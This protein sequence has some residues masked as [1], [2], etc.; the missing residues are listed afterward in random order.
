[1][2]NHWSSI[3][4][5]EGHARSR[6]LETGDWKSD[7]RNRMLDRAR[8]GQR[9]KGQVQ[10]TG[11]QL[12]CRI[13][14]AGGRKG[15]RPGCRISSAQRL[16]DSDQSRTRKAPHE[17]SEFPRIRPLTRRA[18]RKNRVD[19]NGCGKKPSANISVNQRRPS[20]LSGLR[21]VQRRAQK[22]SRRSQPPSDSARLDCEARCVAGNH[23]LQGAFLQ[24]VVGFLAKWRNMMQEP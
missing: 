6:R 1:M 12:P 21:Q 4:P 24:F 5:I 16:F 17:R 14:E 3:R 15:G 18:S 8:G 7:V 22:R 11:S 2:T 9:R 20:N 19:R 13:S 23:G 10:Q